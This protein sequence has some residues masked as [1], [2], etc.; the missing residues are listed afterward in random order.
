MPNAAAQE[1]SG[2]LCLVRAWIRC[3]NLWESCRAQCSQTDVL[4]AVIFKY[5]PCAQR[6]AVRLVSGPRYRGSNPCLPAKLPHKYCSVAWLLGPV[7]GFD[8][9]A[10]ARRSRHESLANPC[11]PAKISFR[12]DTDGPGFPVSNPWSARTANRTECRL[13]EG[14]W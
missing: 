7:L 12:G 3:G 13:L 14:R 2:S 8:R 6:A 9:L 1:P 4:R 11:L 5:A 10:P